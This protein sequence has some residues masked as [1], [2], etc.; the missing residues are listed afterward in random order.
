MNNQTLTNAIVKGLAYTE[1]G[2]KPNLAKPKAGKSGET[3]SIFQYTPDTWKE[4]AKEVFGD[5]NVPM[6]ADTETYVAQQLVGK[7]LKEGKTIPQI[8]SMWNAGKGEPDAY[9]GKFSNGQPSTGVNKEGV[10][11]SVSDYANKVENYTK[12]FLLQDSTKNAQGTT[13]STSPTAPATQST[14]PV[15]T[16]GSSNTATG[17]L[18]SIVS[19]IKSASGP[20]SGLSLG[21]NSTNPPVM[22]GANP[23]LLTTTNKTV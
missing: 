6:N 20:S 5:E 8:A 14:N 12:N 2:G 10:D 18:A 1:N 4:D 21:A 7:W 22:N 13:D 11:Y 23:G 9:T 19:M 3:A 16:S 17:P 15:A